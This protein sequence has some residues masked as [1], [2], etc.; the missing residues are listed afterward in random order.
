MYY[1]V[2]NRVGTFVLANEP[3]FSQGCYTH[4]YICAICYEIG[5]GARVGPIV[6]QSSETTYQKWVY[7]KLR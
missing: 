1:G 2:Y 7:K 3:G 4:S 6:L 5:P